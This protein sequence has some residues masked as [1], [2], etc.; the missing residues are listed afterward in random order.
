MHDISLRAVL[1][2]AALVCSVAATGQP[3][4]AT[5]GAA[6]A[7]D[8]HALVSRHN[9]VLRRL[10]P[11]SPLSVGNGEFAFTADV[12]GLQSFADPYDS[13]IPLGTLSNWG[14]HTA[15]NPDGWRI[16]RFHHAEYDSLGRK[17]GYADIPGDERTPE[18][19][20]LRA[21]PHRLHL[22]RLGFVFTRADG[23]PAGA[24]SLRD[25]EQTLDLWTGTPAQPL[26]DRRRTGG[27]RHGL[28]SHA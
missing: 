3:Q 12:T 17:V 5:S 19:D 25:V 28:P 26:H 13:T 22:G 2:S 9:P 18:I 15:P 8:R 21:N 20:W 23:Q 1:L 16:E 7:I 24:D 4:P 27:C 10:D 11:E 6:P 14:W